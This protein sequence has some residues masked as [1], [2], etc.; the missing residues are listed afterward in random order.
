MEIVK[1]VLNSCIAVIDSDV[2]CL[3]NSLNRILRSLLFGM[4]ALFSY[5]KF[6]NSSLK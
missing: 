4:T 3:I 1:K 6:K 5:N 2:E